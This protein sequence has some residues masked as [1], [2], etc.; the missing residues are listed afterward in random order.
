MY[1]MRKE[2]FYLEYSIGYSTQA[3]LYTHT[4]RNRLMFAKRQRGILRL[5]VGCA[6]THW[7]YGIF[8]PVLQGLWPG[9]MAHHN[10]IRNDWRRWESNP[11]LSITSLNHSTTR[12][13]I[14]ELT[15]LNGCLFYCIRLQRYSNM[16]QREEYFYP[17]H[18][19]Q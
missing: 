6:S 15:I 13:T 7:T 8:S 18:S 11:D 19:G 3:A 5:H 12:I 1:S 14:V 9:C 16:L 4:R 2:F 10:Q 17:K